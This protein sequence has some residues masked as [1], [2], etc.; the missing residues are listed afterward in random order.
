M[1]MHNSDDSN[2]NDEIDDDGRNE[3][4]ENNKYEDYYYDNDET[5]DIDDGIGDYSGKSSG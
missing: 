4:Y 1:I 2:D 5:N 3:E